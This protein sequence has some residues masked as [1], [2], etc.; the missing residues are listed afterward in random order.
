M[1]LTLDT[2][3]N[4]ANGPEFTVGYFVSLSGAQ[5]RVSRFVPPNQL[6][7]IGDVP[8]TF[9]ADGLD[10]AIP[11]AMLDNDDGRMR[12]YVATGID[13]LRGAVTVILDFMPNGDYAVTR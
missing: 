10:A 11:L 5:V 8:V 13:L 1:S 12:F 6:Q 4:L 3:E 7:T 9:V 2:D